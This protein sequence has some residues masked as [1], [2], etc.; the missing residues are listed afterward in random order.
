MTA[1]AEEKTRSAPLEMAKADVER[2]AIVKRTVLVLGR[3]ARLVQQRGAQPVKREVVREPQQ[4]ERRAVR[5]RDLEIQHRAAAWRASR[6]Q[7]VHS[8][9]ETL[10][11][12]HPE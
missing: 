12:V 5:E 6:M 4:L 1:R 11:G 3:D 2:I 9:K 8:Q 7:R 10:R